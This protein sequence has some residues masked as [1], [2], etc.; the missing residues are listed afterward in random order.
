[1]RSVCLEIS[2]LPARLV[3]EITL[4]NTQK[5]NNI[6][7]FGHL[8]GVI[9]VKRFQRK[10][11]KKP[12][13][14]DGAKKQNKKQSGILKAKNKTDAHLKLAKRL[15]YVTVH[16]MRIADTFTSNIYIHTHHISST[17]CLQS[18]TP[19]ATSCPEAEPSARAPREGVPAADR[20]GRVPMAGRTAAQ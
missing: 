9:C 15:E 14:C 13:G 8:S 16:S 20:K 3:G 6:F 10:C 18:F 4:Y 7:I 12:I 19:K 1:M 17:D 5:H 11:L 2:L